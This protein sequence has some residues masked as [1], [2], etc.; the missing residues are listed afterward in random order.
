M[1]Q[2]L[3]AVLMVMVALRR[4]PKGAHKKSFYMKSTTAKSRILQM[5]SHS[6][7]LTEWLKCMSMIKVVMCL[8]S[9]YRGGAVILDVTPTLVI[10]L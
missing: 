6:F 4:S 10:K 8:R 1:E 3:I 9:V 5:I 7:E 2:T